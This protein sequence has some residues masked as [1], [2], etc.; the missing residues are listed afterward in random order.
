MASYLPPTENLTQFNPTVFPNQTTVYD[1][2]TEAKSFFLFYP[3][4]QGT[5][6]MT[7]VNIAGELSTTN[8]NSKGLAYGFNSSLG[9]TT[10]TQ[11]TSFGNSTTVNT[12]NIRDGNSAF[13]RSH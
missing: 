3:Y 9:A 1:T 6:T 4:A 8:N 11:N 10:S 12:A 2:I 5:Q 7:D 13:G